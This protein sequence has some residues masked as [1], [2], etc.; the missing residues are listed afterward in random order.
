[1]RSL[2]RS[3]RVTQ[4]KP[5]TRETTM[6]ALRCFRYIA[7]LIPAVAGPLH[8]QDRLLVPGNPPLTE[9]AVAAAAQFYEWA[10]DVRLSEAQY[11][12]FERLLV[13]RW[14]QP[15]GGA[16]RRSSTPGAGGARSSR[17]APSLA[18]RSSP[19]CRTRFSR[20][21]G[22]ARAATTRLAGSWH[23]TPRP[24]GT[25]TGQP[26]ADEGARG[27]DGRLLGMGAR[28]QA[29]RP[30][31]AGAAAIPDYTMGAARCGV[32]A[33][34]RDCDHPG[35]VDHHGQPRPG[36]RTLLRVQARANVLAE[37]RGNPSEPFNRWRLARYQAA[38][39]LGG[40]RNPILWC[41]VARPHSGMVTQ[42]CEFRE[43][44]WAATAHRA[45]GRRQRAQL[46]QLVVAD[47][48]RGDETARQAFL[49]DSR[50]GGWTSS[51]PERR[52]AA[53]G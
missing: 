47:W 46:Q 2:R 38:H 36:E 31:A 18:A 44:R 48:R 43:W 40:E 32:E 51:R 28:C 11:P 24:P 34:S 39:G 27:S 16:R 33:K 49:A 21:F 45:R 1:M 30:R 22:G 41:P 15:R 17:C 10:L 12:E 14:K 35:V 7:L 9:A 25:R 53:A 13:D 3:T 20:A 5:S 26:A 42:Y 29:R 52:R 6:S 23:V 4:V 19:A 50:P 37:I 8:A